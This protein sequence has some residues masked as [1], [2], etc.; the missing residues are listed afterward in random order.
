MGCHNNDKMISEGKYDH[1]E[2]ENYLSIG[3]G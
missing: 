3:S 1:T 2:L